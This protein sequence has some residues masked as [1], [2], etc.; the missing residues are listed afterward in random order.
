MQPIEKLHKMMIHS[1]MVQASANK[2]QV[3]KQGKS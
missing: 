2:F 1:H 3:Y